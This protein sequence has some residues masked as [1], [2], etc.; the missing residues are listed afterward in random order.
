MHLGVNIIP[1]SK[2]TIYFQG[3]VF[4]GQCQKVQIEISA[5]ARMINSK[6]GILIS[7]MMKKPSSDRKKFQLSFWL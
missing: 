4:Y 5:N 1:W 3:V 6:L 7:C 2:K